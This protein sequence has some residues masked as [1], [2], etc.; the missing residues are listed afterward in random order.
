MSYKTVTINSDAMFTS[1]LVVQGHQQMNIGR[2]VGSLVSYP[3]TPNISAFSGTI[4][5]QRRVAE[6]VE[7]NIIRDVNKWAITAAESFDA[8][9]EDVT[10]LTPET[11]E[12]RIGVKSGEGDNSAPSGILNLRLGTS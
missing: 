12:Y 10:D 3:S 4:T 1:W 2:I 6:D 8:N 9:Q 11:L 5:L 7:D